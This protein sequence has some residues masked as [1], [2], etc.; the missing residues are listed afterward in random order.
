MPEISTSTT[1]PDTIGPTP[2]GV[3]VRMTSPG[4]SVKTLDAYAMTDATE[5]TMSSNRPCWRTSPFTRVSTVPLYT[6]YSVSMNGPS[7]QNVSKPFALW[8]LA[9]AVLQ[10]ARRH[11]VGDRVDPKTTVAASASLTFFAMLPMTIASSPS[12]STCSLWRGN[13][14]ESP[15][16]T[17][18]VF[19]LRNSS[20]CSALRHP[21]LRH[22]RGVFADAHDF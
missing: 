1:S 4:K 14:I 20:G 2:A 21:S 5:C 12:N 11:V 6:V 15:G 8:L 13:T 22:G 17:T 19:G 18:E 3:P 9:V 10:V 7:G 16:P